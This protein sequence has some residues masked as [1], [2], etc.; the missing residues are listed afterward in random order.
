MGTQKPNNAR[1]DGQTLEMTLK[2]SI[3]STAAR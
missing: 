1:E 2:K 3:P